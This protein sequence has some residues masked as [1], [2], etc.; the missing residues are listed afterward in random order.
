M[1]ATDPITAEKFAVLADQHAVLAA[2]VE[3]P[4][5]QGKDYI[6]LIRV[7]AF[8]A[9][10]TSLITTLVV[11]FHSRIVLNDPHAG[12][13][14][15]VWDE[16]LQKRV[17]SEELALRQVKLRGF[18][19]VTTNYTNFAAQQEVQHNVVVDLLILPSL[20]NCYGDG[21]V[22]DDLQWMETLNNLKTAANLLRRGQSADAGV[23]VNV[24]SEDVNCLGL[25]C[26]QQKNG[27]DD[28]GP[29]DPETPE[30]DPGGGDNGGSDNGGGDNGGGDNGGGDNGGDNGGGDNGGGDNGGGDN[31]GGDNG[32]G[33]ENPT[34]PDG[35]N[36][37]SGGPDQNN[38]ATNVM[39]SST[40]VFIVSIIGMAL[41][42]F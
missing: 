3:R 22:I 4:E 5:N 41:I 16:K 35:P 31:G 18:R 29:K 6:S 10:L 15:L 14:L 12:K 8:K 21:D 28:N 36:N 1:T 30:T 42:M 39:V 33:D 27:G 40:S 26:Q 17:L 38:M 24:L 9:F 25:Y 20:T 7:G 32:G 37:P 23:D 11:D 2:M 19:L 34:P 13:A